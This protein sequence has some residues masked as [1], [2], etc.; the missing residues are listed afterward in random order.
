[1]PHPPQH[2]V[3]APIVFIF[4]ADPAWDDDRIAE[5][6]KTASDKGAHIVAQYLSGLTRGDLGAPDAQGRTVTQYL[7]PGYEAQEL[8][9]LGLLEVARCRDLG[10]RV[11]QFH[12]AKAAYVGD[13]DALLD[14]QG[15]RYVFALGEFALRC[16]EA[17]RPGES[18]RSAS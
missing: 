6:L 7:E 11:G 8:K 2:S 10:G 5:E 14:E 16:S 3:D 1:M 17:P 9:R 13:L 18:K 12:A 15:A 4:S